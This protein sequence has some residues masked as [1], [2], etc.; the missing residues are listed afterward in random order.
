[1]KHFLTFDELLALPEMFNA[2]FVSG[3][4]GK[5]RKIMWSHIIELDDIKD[6]IQKDILVILTGVAFKDYEASLIRILSILHE[7][8][9][10]GLLVAMGVYIM[11]I[12][13]SVQ[14]LSNQYQIP[15][16][17]IT[18]ENRLVEITYQIAEKI[19]KS[20]KEVT[21]PYQIENAARQQLDFLHSSKVAGRD[22]LYQTL[23][24][25]L[26]QNGNMSNAARILYIHRNTMKYRIKKLEEIMQCK[27][28]DENTC[29]HLKLAIRME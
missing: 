28:R 5:N 17:G 11:S 1:M 22:E 10:A 13:K 7:K 2:H 29:F 23:C 4:A 21:I 6:W 18:Q 25:F 3:E 12:P 19:F 8:E 16:I 20:G 24:V 15:I 27:L 14:D 26:E 9:A